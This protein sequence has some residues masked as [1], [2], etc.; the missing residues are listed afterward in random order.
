MMRCL[1]LA[2]AFIERNYHVHFLYKKCL[3]NILDVLH[4]NNINTEEYLGDNFT[5]SELFSQISM[6][7]LVV[8]DYSLSVEEQTA[9]KDL[10]IQPKQH[11]LKVIAIDDAIDLGSVHADLIVNHAENASIDYYMTRFSP[12]S[13]LLGKQYA[14]IRSEF[15]LKANINTKENQRSRLLVTIGATDVKEISLD[16][17]VEINKYLPDTPVTLVLNRVSDSQRELLS[18]LE[19]LPSIE[20]L[21]NVKDMAEHMRQSKL[22]ITAAGGT[23][24]ELACCGVPSVALVIAD[25][26]LP[27]LSSFD[28][29]QYYKAIDARAYQPNDTRYLE[30]NQRLLVE[31]VRQTKEL[32]RD[33]CLLN[34]MNKRAKQVVDGKGCL[35]I[36]EAFENTI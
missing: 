32:W 15:R 18:S 19:R 24:N 2:Q 29:G 23:L 35:R 25:N 1:A 22:A 26:Q 8:D 9:L 30:S 12:E 11:R 36:I 16:L 28:N 33:N 6:D 34:D 21:S 14:L 3:I 31:I 4:E 17:V 5:G 10:L 20:V 7:C 13:L 27:A